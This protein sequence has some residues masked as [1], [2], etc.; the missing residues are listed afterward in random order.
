MKQI[1]GKLKKGGALVALMML[2]GGNAMASLEGTYTAIM[3]HKDTKFFQYATVTL[4]TV[5]P[6]GG[7]L[8]ISANVRIFFGDLNSVE[9]LTYEFPTVER[10]PLSGQLTMREAGNDVSL[11]GTLRTGTNSITGDWYSTLVGKVGTFKAIKDE[12]PE[13]PEGFELVKTVSGDFRGTITSTHSEINLP[14]RASITLVTRQDNGSEEGGIL[15][16]GSTRLYY[17]EFG[18]N[19]YEQIEFENIQFNFY[20]RFLTARTS[21]WGIVYKGTLGLDGSFTGLVYADGYGKVGNIKLAA[22][23]DEFDSMEE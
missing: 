18:S 12:V 21:D 6:G 3:Q 5:N 9:Y 17:G 13:I 14:E 22:E 8:K 19:E 23:G 11:I 20:N 2:V 7:E 10:N 1:M 16:T 15:I 4:R